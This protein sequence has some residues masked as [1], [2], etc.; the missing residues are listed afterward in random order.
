[1]ELIERTLTNIE[2]YLN[3]KAKESEERN[4]KEIEY[5]IRQFTWKLKMINGTIEL[6][7]NTPQQK[8]KGTKI[9]TNLEKSISKYL[10][11][12]EQYA[13]KKL[14]GELYQEVTELNK[15]ISR[16]EGVVLK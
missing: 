16:L 8:C 11:F 10:K 2:N 1:M 14:V 5:T 15:N 13:Q 3:K 6:Q 9:Y 4:A 7:R 12:A